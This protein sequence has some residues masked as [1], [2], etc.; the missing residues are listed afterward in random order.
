LQQ[1]L[2]PNEMAA[3]HERESAIIQLE[4]TSPQQS[5]MLV[6]KDP[7]QRQQD[8]ELGRLEQEIE[9]MADVFTEVH[10]LV[11]DQGEVVGKKKKLKELFLS[12]KIVV[13]GSLSTKNR[14]KDRFLR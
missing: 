14:L 13:L 7:L 9:D 1:Q 3:M 8:E 4:V 6:E 12:I 10:K 2:S 11:H 5:Q